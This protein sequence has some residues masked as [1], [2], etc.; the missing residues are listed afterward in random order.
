MKKISTQFAL[1]V[2]TLCRN[3]HL[4]SFVAVVA[5]TVATSKQHAKMHLWA[6]F[7]W[8]CS[9][10][11]YFF[12]CFFSFSFSL[13][14]QQTTRSPNLLFMLCSAAPYDRTDR[15][16]CACSIVSHKYMYCIKMLCQGHTIFI[17]SDSYRMCERR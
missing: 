9:R 6:K 13:F 3:L 7:K 16:V 4:L 10:C 12:F 14:A 17:R 15:Q 11:C 1:T 8:S 2:R 5:V